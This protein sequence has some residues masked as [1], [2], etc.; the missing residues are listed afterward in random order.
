MQV[1]KAVAI[2]VI[3]FRGVIAVPA[4]IEDLD[5]ECG[6]LGVMK[7]DKDTLPPGVNPDNVRKCLNHPESLLREKGDKKI[8]QR[9][10]WKGG[11]AAPAEGGAGQPRNK[12]LARGLVARVGK[13]A[14]SSCLV[15]KAT[16]M[17]VD[18]AARA[19]GTL[20]YK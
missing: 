3:Y 5:A 6:A 12:A 9:Q 1:L 7:I 4:S 11:D 13:I 8:F 16:A 17:I 10:C 20:M 14:M 18:A 15:V 2:A 19:P